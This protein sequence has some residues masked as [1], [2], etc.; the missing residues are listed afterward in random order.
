[1]VEAMANAVSR[2]PTRAE[3]PHVVSTP[4]ASLLPHASEATQVS[5]RSGGAVAQFFPSP[6]PLSS[7]VGSQDAPLG[8]GCGPAQVV[9][10]VST[11][12]LQSVDGMHLFNLS[13]GAVAQ[14]VRSL[15]HSAD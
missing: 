5:L 12:L 4:S 6:H 7:A 14:L 2:V 1:M 11:V 8:V 9:F 3:A 13:A 15:V 10:T